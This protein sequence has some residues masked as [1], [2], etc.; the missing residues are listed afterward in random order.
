M[1]ALAAGAAHLDQ[2]ASGFAQASRRRAFASASMQSPCASATRS[3]SHAKIRSRLARAA[4][5]SLHPIWYSGAGLARFHMRKTAFHQKEVG[6]VKTCPRFVP[7]TRKLRVT[8]HRSV[9]HAEH[10]NLLVAGIVEEQGVWLATETWQGLVDFGI[11]ASGWCLTLAMAAVGLDSD[12]SRLR[13]LG[14]RPLAV[15]FAAAVTVGALAAALIQRLQPVV[16]GG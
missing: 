2:P 11:G 16:A 1:H 14:V 10:T 4:A 3:M 6:F 8:V 15:G 7:P 12:L 13:A 9:E 5:L